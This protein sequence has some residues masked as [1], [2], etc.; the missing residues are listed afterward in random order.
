[1]AHRLL[2]VHPHPDDE[3]IACGGLIARAVAD[4]HDVHVVTCT[5][6]EE[7]ENQAGIDLGGR[8]MADVRRD[9]MADAVDAL[10]GP[11]HTWLG[12]RDSGMA[13]ESSNDHPRSFHAAPLD[14]AAARLASVVREVRPHVVVSD[15]EDGTYGHPDHVKA[16]AVTARA[17]AMAADPSFADGA[18]PWRVP[19]RYVF[20]VSRER[21]WRM[22][23]SLLDAGLPS[24]WVE[25]GAAPSGPSELPFGTDDQLITTS[26]DVSDVLDRKRAAMAAHRSQIGPESFFLNTPPE[27]DED[28][29][30]VEDLVLRE[31]EAAPGADG[32]EHDVFAG[33]PS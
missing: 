28:A 9:E 20:T 15:A 25:D 6:G 4:G 5:G 8:D 18:E 2:C 22:H 23:R 17:V 26:V 11:D 13:G 29:F 30:A 19:K 21:M 3:S 14:E 10:G 24:P 7:G 27:L 12:Y 16:S 32:R 1:M 31:G 33:L